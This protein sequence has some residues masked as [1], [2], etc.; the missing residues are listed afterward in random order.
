MWMVGGGRPVGQPGRR[1]HL[2]L[3]F[4]PSGEGGPL[5]LNGGLGEVW[6]NHDHDARHNVLS[7]QTVV[8]TRMRSKCASSM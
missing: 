2:N 4:A 3:S 6:L 7:A 1:A 8:F 5:A